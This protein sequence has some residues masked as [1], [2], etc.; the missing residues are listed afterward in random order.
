MKK[1]KRHRGIYM[2][3]AACLLIGAIGGV[4][5]YENR[6]DQKVPDLQLAVGQSGYDLMAGITY[7]SEK[8][9]LSV[10]DTG[11]LD[12]NRI[13]KYEV[14]Y[15]LTPLEVPSTEEIPDTT[16]VPSTEVIPDSTEVPPTETVPGQTPDQ[17]QP[18]STET[19]PGTTPD[20]TGTPD[21]DTPDA[22]TTPD[23][24]GSPGAGT[25]PDQTDTPDTSTPDAGTTPD[26]TDALGTGTTSGTT[27]DKTDTPASGTVTNDPL[28]GE[29]EEAQP[30][31]NSGASAKPT[32]ISAVAESIFGTVSAAEITGTQTEGVKYLTRTVWV[33]AGTDSI[34]IGYEEEDVKI[35]ANEALYELVLI[36]DDTE[37]TTDTEPA[38]QMDQ[39][40][41][42]G[43]TGTQ[44]ET[45]EATEE[46]EP[47]YELVLKKPELLTEGIRVTDSAASLYN[48][49]TVTVTD[50]SELKNAVNIETAED[51]TKTIKSINFGTYTIEVTAEDP[52]SGKKASCTRTVTVEGIRFDAPT[53]YIGTQNTEYDLTADMSAV[54]ESGNNA[55]IYVI[56]E[57]ELTAARET[58]T[59]TET[60]EEKTQF[61]KGTYHVTLG[62]KHPV[63]GEEFTID[64]EI[65]VVEGYY[66][67]APALEIMAGS[68]DYDLTEG[69]ELRSA[70]T[71]ETVADAK[72]MVEDMSDLERGITEEAAFFGAEENIQTAS[73]EITEEDAINIEGTGVPYEAVMPALAEGEYTVTL[74]AVNPDDEDETITVQRSVNVTSMDRIIQNNRAMFFTATAYEERINKEKHREGDIDQIGGVVELKTLP[75]GTHVKIDNYTG[76][77]K[78]WQND[79]M[80]LTDAIPEGY[81]QK[82]F[83][84][85]N[86]GY[87][88][89]SSGYYYEIK[90][91]I[92]K[93]G[94]DGTL[95]HHADA[96]ISWYSGSMIRRIGNNVQS[97][98][99]IG[100][101][102]ILVDPTSN[103]TLVKYEH[104]HDQNVVDRYHAEY[105]RTKFQNYVGTAYATTDGYDGRMYY[106]YNGQLFLY[107]GQDNGGK[108][109]DCGE[110]ADKIIGDWTHFLG[111]QPRNKETMKDGGKPDVSVVARQNLDNKNL[112]I[113]TIEDSVTN[114]TPESSVLVD[115]KGF[116]FNLP[117]AGEKGTATSPMILPNMQYAIKN[118][119]LLKGTDDVAVGYKLKNDSYFKLEDIKKATD[120]TN[121][122][123]WNITA[124]NT[125]TGSGDFELVAGN[126]VETVNV[127]SDHQ[128]NVTIRQTGNH[129]NTNTVT[130]FHQTLTL[131]L[132]NGT[133]NFANL[134]SNNKADAADNNATIILKG[135]G[136][137][138]KMTG[139]GIVETGI[140][141]VQTDDMTILKADGVAA[142][143]PAIKIHNKLLSNG[144]QITVGKADGSN[145]ADGEVIAVGGVTALDATDFKLACETNNIYAVNKDSKTI[146]AK[147]LNTKAV[148]VMKDNVQVG[149][150]HTYA[151]AFNYIQINGHGGEYTVRILVPRNY[152][153]A[154]QTAFGSITTEKASKITLEA[155]AYNTYGFTGIDNGYMRMRIANSLAS[156]E[157]PKNVDVTFTN[158]VVRRSNADGTEHDT[159]SIAKNGGKLTL[160]TNYNTCGEKL[161]LYGGAFGQ[162]A[163]P[164]GENA[165]EI[166]LNIGL[167]IPNI[168]NYDK[169]TVNENTR[170]SGIINS[171]KASDYAGET[172]LAGGKKLAL[173]N[174]SGTRKMGSLKLE[175]AATQDATFEFAK[176]SGTTSATDN[177]HLVK[178]TAEQP[179]TGT[180]TAYKIEVK[181]SGGTTPVNNDIVF[182]LPN[183][184][185]KAANVTTQYLK[186]G[187]GGKDADGKNIKMMPSAGNNTI[188]LRNASVGLSVSTELTSITPFMTLKDALEDANN[189]IRAKEQQTPGQSYRITFFGDGY[190]IS[191]EDIAALKNTG[192]ATAGDITWTSKIG[193]NSQQKQETLANANTVY[194]SGNISLFGKTN[195][196]EDIKLEASGDT[197]IFAEGKPLTVDSG[198][199]GKGTIN[200]FGGSSKGTLATPSTVVVRSGEFTAVYGGGTKA[201][202]ANATVTMSGGTIGTIY[203][204]G[205]TADGT[206][207]G[208][209]TIAITGGTVTGSI[210]GGGHDAAVNGNT[211]ITYTVANAAGEKTD[212]I[213][214]VS[215]SGTDG[216]GVLKGNVT[217]AGAK[218]TITIK[219]AGTTH[220]GVLSMKQLAGFDE[221]KLGNE[222]NGQ[223]EKTI[224][225]VR[226]RFDSKAETGTANDRT[227]SVI[228]HSTTLVLGNTTQGH[229]GKLN[230]QG[231]SVLVVPRQADGTSLPV[232]V[233]NS[234]TEF[235]QGAVL[236]L[237]V[238]NTAQE[239]HKSAMNEQG[240]R[241]ITFTNNNNPDKVLDDEHLKYKDELQTDLPV[242]QETDK[243]DAKQ[244]HILFGK[245]KTHLA[246]G[247][248]EYPDNV[249][250]TAA[251]KAAKKN[252]NLV[253]DKDN[254]HEVRTDKPGGYVVVMPKTA[255]ADADSTKYTVMDAQFKTSGTF[256][257][258]MDSVTKFPVTFTRND[259]V[260]GQNGC[261]EATASVEI[262]NL[263]TQTNWYILHT[264]CAQGDESVILLDLDAPEKTADAVKSELDPAT[265]NYTFELH[266]KDAMPTDKL[267]SQK[268]GNDKYSL[269]YT[270]NGIK[271]AYWT[272]GKLDETDLTAA[273]TEAV[274]LK[275]SITPDKD[276][277]GLYG[278]AEVSLLAGGTTVV[279]ADYT[280]KV[281]VTVPKTVVDANKNGALYVYAKD[282]LNNTIRV[283]VPLNENIIDVSVPLQVNVIA[284]KKPD[285]G[286]R[287]LLAPVCEVKNN[288]QQQVDAQIV[289]FENKNT[290]KAQLDFSNKDKGNNFNPN[291]IALFLKG[292]DTTTFTE[293]NVLGIT[294]QA[295]IQLGTLN[296]AGSAGSAA[297]YTFD[298]G[299]NVTD[300]NIPDGYVT[301]YLSYHF[302]VK[303]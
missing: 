208:D 299:Y 57:D 214:T 292:A 25:T 18:P 269:E 284:V 134:T 75:D 88:G 169:L 281:V 254:E 285:G 36:E 244:V 30:E 107:A 207:T 64:R 49:A 186:D 172:I 77:N 14:T 31:D 51:G 206:L 129:T 5:A 101:P 240:D 72:I 227:D 171:E 40:D 126:G 50:D 259:Q 251:K 264:V 185:N 300:I 200:L 235:A 271:A 275:D 73:E 53:L 114:I 93:Y 182:Y 289:G 15:A 117:K 301:G 194:L 140:L 193:M 188:V 16:E 94:T 198:V 295:P 288:G 119:N 82:I 220:T 191:D 58:V 217:K 132:S 145:F 95:A 265:Q 204:G 175:Q 250:D 92:Y 205:K 252:V 87:W 21:T 201:Q 41:V 133:S 144:K 223:V 286:E 44:T 100:L 270:A 43:E 143:D 79:T 302:K 149:E 294:V 166:I 237:A 216:N 20:Q 113:D 74:A 2:L 164:A 59:D 111:E 23:Q 247:W 199:T 195:K 232:K 290:Q 46:T 162:T 127:T 99:V 158:I 28:G 279:Q 229:I 103:T 60:G 122:N 39:A 120:A 7:D 54:D 298:A 183:A 174:A 35:K 32:D 257:S 297:K 131:E 151:E 118:L 11:G 86:K 105:N 12:I 136:A 24:S 147:K 63:T 189:G 1:N 13:G 253:Y 55:E 154:D 268:P 181:Y 236:K 84:D 242:T 278:T 22:G 121:G 226:E 69:V 9:T 47:Q 157:L 106:S 179:L 280:A 148:L 267:P 203:G 303:K 176:A 76:T 246:A 230:V 48:G 137:T 45:A 215:G 33:V 83:F 234:T 52:G 10:E 163:K 3:T 184:N 221:L 68:T 161:D 266:L 138:A 168:Y 224:V 109:R 142:T 102:R 155:E 192:I 276:T 42:T 263:D 80:P 283:A 222:T 231:T 260:Q 123:N 258:A 104:M 98:Q 19:A 152:G 248:A 62:A 210:Y 81:N 27:T 96:D 225:K 160:G 255:S 4:A 261:H 97:R 272:V 116:A 273:D 110:Y 173:S 67:Y 249:P 150:F 91:Y 282:G 170:V 17:T 56:N 262:S 291:E 71:D 66:I 256:S 239:D 197:N 187:F 165:S 293:K 37:Q 233:D 108:P 167:T 38:A 135:S 180:N 65:Q 190:S 238:M 153:Q 218:R 90:Y 159:V 156:A 213:D 219:T 139:T 277:N 124:A 287:E 29:L 61:I 6:P 211:N 241:I 212:M 202:N 85:L 141:D 243:T 196:L 209:T 128:K 146:V 177:Q 228:L 296:A 70:D 34:F 274:K 130:N 112:N 115:G 8:Y 26:K 78:T 178:L 125:S 245:P 89:A